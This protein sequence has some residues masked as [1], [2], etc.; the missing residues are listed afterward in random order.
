MCTLHVLKPQRQLQV[1]RE[2]IEIHAPLANRLGIWRWKGELEDLAFRTMA[3]ETY[4]EIVDELAARESELEQGIDP[5]ISLL[6]HHLRLEGINAEITGRHK[7]IHS[8]YRKM[9]RKEIPLERVY[10]IRALRVIVESVS[11]CYQ[12]MGVVHSLWPPIPGEFDDYI[13]KPKQN[14]YQSL[15][16][17]VLGTDGKTLEVQIRTAY[18]H[19][20]AEYGVASHWRYKEGSRKDRMFEEKI[21]TLRAQIEASSEVQDAR[22]FVEEVTTD[23]FEDRVYTFTPRGKVIDLPF[24]STPID[25]AYYVH[26]EIGHKARGAMVNGRWVPLDYTLKTGDQVEVITAKRAAPSRDWLNPVLG[27]VKT[28]RARSKIRRWFRQLDREQ[29]ITFGRTVLERELKRLGVADMPHEEVAKLFAYEDV[30]D[31]M[32]AIGFGDVNSQQIAAR[33][34]EAKRKE[35]EESQDIL[36]LTPLSDD[37]LPDVQVLGTG[38]LLTRLAR[39]CNPIPDEPIVGYVTRGKGITVHRRDCPNAINPR[40]PERLIE[41]IWGTQPRTFP[42]RVSISVYDRAGLLHD[43]SGVLTHENVNI[44]SISQTKLHNVVY[45]SITL[46]VTDVGQLGRVL[47]RLN[48]VPNVIEARR[49]VH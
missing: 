25:F 42:V 2:T 26:T 4:Q 1:A 18:M 27:Y 49:Q 29:N 12:T 28:S 11:E 48:R 14:M 47:T 45:L 38:G 31:F 22:A 15:H 8:I 5:Q 9:Q 17:A 44:A 35:D 16:T 41:V 43:I 30:G 23:L 19:R 24:G 7:H 39:C 36:P 6:Q 3:P 21:A 10:D 37:E 13:A 33:V 40:N 46:E 34:M 20:V 32:A